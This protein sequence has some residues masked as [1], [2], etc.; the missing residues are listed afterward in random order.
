MTVPTYTVQTF[1]MKGIREQ[2]SDTI[3]NI[4]PMDTPLF[5]KFSKGT[6]KTRTPEW[7]IDAHRAANPNNAVVEGSDATNIQTTATTR[8]KNVVQLFEGTVQVSTTSEAVDAAGRS[9]EMAYQIAKEGKALRTDIEARISGN[10]ASVLGDDSTAG[11]M[12]GYEAWITTN[13][14]RAGSQGGFNTGTG[15][16]AAA[17]DGTQRALTETI[18]KG[19]IKTCWENGA[20]APMVVTGPFNKQVISSFAGIAQ[21]TNEVKASDMVTIVGAADVYVSDFGRHMIMPSRLSRDRSVL[22]VDPAY[23]E[24]MFLQPFKTEPLAKTG[25]SIRR[26]I[27]CE[28]TLKSRNEQA[29]GIIA[30]LTTS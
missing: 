2:L 13:D 16:V 15:L 23:W 18:F 30:D 20:K 11:A 1:A 25:H 24:V 27:S 10:Y 28:C 17:S 7:Q 4:D 26:M 12:A 22:L 19:A 21:A 14:S 3:S 5:S 9:S 8:L 29:S 6:A